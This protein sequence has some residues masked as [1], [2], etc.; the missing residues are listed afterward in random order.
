MALLLVTV[1]SSPITDYQNKISRMNIDGDL[2]FFAELQ[3][4]IHYQSPEKSE[5]SLDHVLCCILLNK[6]CQDIVFIL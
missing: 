1:K 5:L 6:V 2:I 4:D 3:E